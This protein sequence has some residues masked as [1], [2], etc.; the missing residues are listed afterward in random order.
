MKDIFLKNSNDMDQF[1]SHNFLDIMQDELILVEFGFSLNVTD[2]TEFIRRVNG[3]TSVLCIKIDFELHNLSEEIENLLASGIKAICLKLKL[4][5]RADKNHPIQV[6]REKHPIDR[7][8]AALDFESI[9]LTYKSSLKIFCEIQ[10]GNEHLQELYPTLVYLHDKNL[11]WTLLNPGE[12]HF[13]GSCKIISDA[14]MQ[15]RIR[16]RKSMN[17]YFSESHPHAKFW[18]VRTNNLFRGP[19]IVD[20]DVANTCTHNCVFCG[21]Y[22]DKT[23]QR[24]RMNADNKLPRSLTQLMAAKIDREDCFKIIAS[25]PDT[26]EQVQFGGLGDPFTH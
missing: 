25:L 23:L 13:V 26:V 21:L 6:L 22:S 8:Q 20:I 14:F 17:I 7:S 18:N 24:H 15:L 10:L 11:K 5:P 12:L 9:W 16:N 19:R 4:K 3:K 2:K 1:F